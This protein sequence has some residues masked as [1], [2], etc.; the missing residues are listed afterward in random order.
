MTGTNGDIHELCTLM[1]SSP[2]LLASQARGDIKIMDKDGKP[3]WFAYPR[4]T[5]DESAIVYH[6]GKKLFLYTLKDG[7]TRKVS[8]DNDADYRY[9]HGEATPK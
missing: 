8:T 2:C 6:A 9:P 5:K 3:V 1:K 4:F 7:S